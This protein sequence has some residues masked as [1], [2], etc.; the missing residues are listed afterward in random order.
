MQGNQTACVCVFAAAGVDLPDGGAAAVQ[1]RRLVQ[2]AAAAGEHA[3]QDGEQSPL[4]RSFARSWCLC[5]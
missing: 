2:R 5:D 1:Q 4:A 3:A